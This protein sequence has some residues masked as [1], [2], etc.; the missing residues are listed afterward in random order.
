MDRGPA[1][2]CLSGSCFCFFA[3]LP[4][5]SSLSFSLATFFLSGC[6]WCLTYAL[7]SDFIVILLKES[8]VSLA[9]SLLPS[10]CS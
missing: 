6:G 1:L 5:S 3:S 8:L 7:V 9:P 2:K 4:A 10:F